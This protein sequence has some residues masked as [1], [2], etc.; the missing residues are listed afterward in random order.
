MYVTL[1]LGSSAS[2]HPPGQSMSLPGWNIC[3]YGSIASISQTQFHRQFNILA[4]LASHPCGDQP[5]LKWLI[6][7]WQGH[8]EVIAGS[9]PGYF[10][11]CTA[12]CFIWKLVIL[13]WN[14]LRETW[15]KPTV[16]GEV[17]QNVPT[18]D[19]Y[20]RSDLNLFNVSVVC[21]VY[22]SHFIMNWPHVKC[23]FT[24]IWTWHPKSSHLHGLL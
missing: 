16:S 7:L 14:L 17:V 15:S 18:T 11:S 5:G 6:H 21:V 4:L 23:T 3:I 12:W 2:G 1:E 8:L 10:F 9:G 20:Q 24:S 22:V 19:A 13:S